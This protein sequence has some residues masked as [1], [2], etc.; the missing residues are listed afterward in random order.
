MICVTFRDVCKRIQ[1][2]PTN[3]LTL[4][5]WLCNAIAQDWIN[6]NTKSCIPLCRKVQTLT[7]RCR[8]FF[9][10]LTVSGVTAVRSDRGVM[11]IIACLWDIFNIKWKK[12][13]YYEY[14]TRQSNSIFLFVLCSLDDT[15][16]RSTHTCIKVFHKPNLKRSFYNLEHFNIYFY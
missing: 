6:Q 11:S 1:G 14:K 3:F 4:K 16:W 7:R 9:I 5:V 10:I 15:L 8:N 13:H 12:T 2:F